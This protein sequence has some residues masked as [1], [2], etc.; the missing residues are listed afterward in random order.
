MHKTSTNRPVEPKPLLGQ[1]SQTDT[2]REFQAPSPATEKTRSPIGVESRPVRSPTIVLD[3]DSSN[4]I[5]HSMKTFSVALQYPYSET[6]LL[7][8]A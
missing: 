2:E 6:L 5:N 7:T 3:L 1:N 4:H 8:Q